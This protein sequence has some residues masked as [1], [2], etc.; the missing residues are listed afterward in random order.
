MVHSEELCEFKYGTVIGCHLYNKSFC[1]ISSLLVY[2][3]YVCLQIRNANVKHATTGLRSSG[4]LFHGVMNHTSHLEGLMGE[5]GFGK[6][7]ENVTCLIALS[8][9]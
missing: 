4:N 6:H 7:Q 1:E 5:S 2:Q 8:Q 3:P 9:L